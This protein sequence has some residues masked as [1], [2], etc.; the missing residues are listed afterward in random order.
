[1]SSITVMPLPKG[2]CMQVLKEIPY[3]DFNK[4]TETFQQKWRTI[5]CDKVT[6]P[7]EELCPHHL[8]LLREEEAEKHRRL[9]KVKIAKER[10]ILQREMLEHSPLAV[11]PDKELL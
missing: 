1:M 3:Q 8:L 5:T 9:E 4:Q 10:R 7:G 11:R 2:S 6:D